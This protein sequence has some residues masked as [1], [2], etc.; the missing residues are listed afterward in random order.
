MIAKNLQRRVAERTAE[1]RDARDTLQRQVDIIDRHVIMSRA[2]ANGVISYASDAFAR[3]SKYPK[4]EI[5]GQ[6]HALFGHPDTPPEIYNE[7][8]TASLA[9]KRWTGELKS[10]AK[11]GS[12]YWVDVTVEPDFDRD[13]KYIGYTSLRYDI[14]DKKRIEVLSETDRLTGLPNRLKLDETFEHEIE[15]AIRYPHALSIII[16]DIDH[17]K[18]VNDTHGHQVGDAVLVAMSGLVRSHI[19]NID[20]LG[21]WG[22]EEFLIIC[23]ETGM[24]GA[25][26]LAENLRA[27]IAACD[28]P[29]VGQK[30]ASFGVT[31]MGVGDGEDDMVRRADDALYR[32]KEG[33]RNRV[34]TEAPPPPASPAAAHA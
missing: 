9:G 7:L 1:L 17:F 19:R 27:A 24:E 16:F 12:P 8:R 6:T 5:V 34:E 25:R 13:G 28:F 31:E 30:T 14:T 11:D 4:E 22:G 15:R 32:A 23:P 29:T 10:M 3:I 21:R 20:M 2:D 18:Q 33:G 26:K